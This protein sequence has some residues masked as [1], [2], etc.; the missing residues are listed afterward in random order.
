[1]FKFPSLKRWFSALLFSGTFLASAQ[2]FYAAEAGVQVQLQLPKAGFVTVAIDDANGKRVRN[3]IAEKWLE[4]GSQS[5]KWNGL[6]DAG[7]PLPPGNYRWKG[8]MHA[9]VT[10]EFE[11]AF[12]SPG[13]PPWLTAEIP[14]QYYVRASGA[15]GWLSDHGRPITAH[16]DGQH[17]YFG[18]NIAEAGH[19]IMQLDQEGNKTWGTLWLGLSGANAIFKKNDI[20]Y[21]AGEKGWMRDSLAVHRLDGTSHRVLNKPADTELP[22]GET[23]FIKV[24]SADFAGIKGMV[25]TDDYVVLS[26]GDKNRLALFDVNSGKYVRDVPLPAAGAIT[27]PEGDTLLAVSGQTVVRINVKNGTSQV[28]IKTGLVEPAGLAVSSQ[29]NIL[30]S[31]IAESEQRIKIFSASG[32]PQR[33]IGTSGGRVEGPFDPARFNV[34]RALAV[35]AKDQVWIGED[36]NLPKRI[37]VWTL[38]GKLVREWFGPPGYGGGGTLDPMDSTRG[39]YNGMMFEVAPWPKAST[40]KAVLFDPNQHPDLPHTWRKGYEE[41]LPEAAVYRG[42]QLYLMHDQGYGVKKILIG[43]VTQGRFMPRVIFGSLKELIQSWQELHPDYIESITTPE[44]KHS[45]VFL[46]QDVNGDGKAD[47]SE[48]QI[49]PEWRFGAM[50]AMRSWPSLNLYARS[51][52]RNEIMVLAPEPRTDKLSYDLKAAQSIPLPPEVRQRGLIALSPDLAGNIL[53][54]VGTQKQQGDP[55]NM[56]Y[57]IA[58]DGRINWTYP[59]PF[60]ANWHN[61]PRLKLGDIQ[62]TLNVE[63][64]VALDGDRGSVF[65]LNGN[66]GAR[67]LLT[68][69]GLFVSQIYGD[70][71]NAPVMSSV[72]K[73]TRG[74]RM[75]TYSLSDECFLG[76]LGKSAGEIYQVVGKDS[77]NVMKVRGL[78][79]LQR[80][81]GGHLQLTTA[82]QKILTSELEPAPI[83]AVIIGGI[84][85]GWED[86]QA[87]KLLDADPSAKFAIGYSG[88]G[89]TLNMTVENTSPF[90]NAGEDPKTLFKTGNAVDFRF[91]IAEKANPA[92]TSPVPG[93]MRFIFSTLQDKPVAVR[94][95]FVVPNT[96]QDAKSIFASPVGSVEVDDVDIV[97]EAKV[98]I[99]QTSTGWRLWAYLPW[100][101]LGFD[102]APTGEFQGDVGLI[103]SDPE[104]TRAVARHYY[105]DRGSQVVS[106]LPGEVRVDPSEWGTISF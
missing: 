90:A 13:T 6:D 81:Q 87:Y 63:G 49:Q 82:A 46:W 93:D 66:K 21:V 32:T 40:L 36:S 99:E 18:S 95:R 38:S 28:L 62:H 16:S 94:Y 61:S 55:A 11:G 30:V 4:A 84:G 42:N 37:S 48:V 24:K 70:M 71:R 25:V 15:G 20:L 3:L 52:D 10:S 31:D 92:R 101:S 47:P 19:S 34:P 104:G 41:G 85:K 105:F 89:M 76:W 33:A 59:N 72:Q 60:P 75:D 57:S 35:D 77:S 80:L 22:R 7:E 45:G 69:D 102:K 26:L 83:E 65:Q 96:P 100:R 50:W 86:A 27:K 73:V 88:G 68:T 67:F 5:V 64:I 78:D 106:D 14:G 44:S 98:R 58:P 1:M 53:V 43:E 97:T 91:S 9:G 8:L 29:G 2:I 79:T 56:F 17:I 54:N 39:F 12:N 103:L 23:A 51:A 74:L